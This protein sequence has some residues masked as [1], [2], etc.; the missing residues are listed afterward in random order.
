MPLW[1]PRNSYVIASRTERLA[2]GLIWIVAANRSMEN[3]RPWALAGEAAASR[4]ENR[5]SGRRMRSA[6]ERDA[7]HLAILGPI[8]LEVLPSDE[9]A[10][11]GDHVGGK[12]L[13]GRVEVA[14]D[15]VV[16]APGVLHGVLD[17]A[18]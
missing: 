14:H 11:G 7:G 5:T 12:A 17:L 18:E 15:R 2:S 8:Q 1:R 6:P 3:A 9:T 16:I 10:E 13:D 4:A